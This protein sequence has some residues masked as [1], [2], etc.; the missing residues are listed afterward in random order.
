MP[1]TNIQ[2]RRLWIYSHSQQPQKI[3]YLGINLTKEMKDIYN[4]NLKPLMKEIGKTLENEN[5]HTTLINR[6]N[7]YCKNEHSTRSYLQIKYNLNQNSNL[8]LC[9]NRKVIR[10]FVQNH[11]RLWITKT[12]LSN[13]NV[14]EIT[15]ADLMI[16]YRAIVI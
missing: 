5:T 1:T 16:H 12:I 6:Q 11:K 8:I 2:R 14:K 10:K 7:Q 9:R 15:I 13:N 3:K 4:E